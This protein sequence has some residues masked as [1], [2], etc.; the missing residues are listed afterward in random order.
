VSALP[1]QE[2]GLLERYGLTRQDAD[3][4]VWAILPAGQRRHGSR[5]VAL[6]LRE[7]GGRWRLLGLAARLP[8]AGVV[9]ALLARS[10]GRLGSVWGDPPLFGQDGG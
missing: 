7:M 8:G 2:P 3:R 10:R 1:S 6:V 4:W 5:A 9:Y